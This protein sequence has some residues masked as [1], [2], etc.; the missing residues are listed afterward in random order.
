MIASIIPKPNKVK[1]ISR[2]D[3]LARTCIKNYQSL[4]DKQHE[5]QTV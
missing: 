2:D 4:K 5:D 3:E 1:N